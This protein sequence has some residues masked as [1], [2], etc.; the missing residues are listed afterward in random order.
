MSG[1]T[2]AKASPRICPT[3]SS[4][5]RASREYLVS[6]RDI[7]VDEPDVAARRLYES[8]GFTN[9]TDRANG[10]FMY[11][12]ERALCRASLTVGMDAKVS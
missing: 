8:L 11:V 1:Q 2:I 10:P 7:G 6:H 9:R 4:D 12:Y 5:R 3:L